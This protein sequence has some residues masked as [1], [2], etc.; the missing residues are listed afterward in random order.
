MH[1]LTSLSFSHPLL[2]PISKLF[3]P[4]GL[5]LLELL[6][7]LFLQCISFSMW[8]VSWLCSMDDEELG[9]DSC[10]PFCWWTLET[11]VCTHS[12]YHHLALSGDLVA[13]FH[14]PQREYTA[15]YWKEQRARWANVKTVCTPVTW[16][17]EKAKETEA[18]LLFSDFKQF[19]VTWW[20]KSVLF[21][22]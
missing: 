15:E 13:T 7:W 17:V 20:Q 21:S 6:C 9:D 16:W 10:M 12:L 1:Q 19:G 5:S 11:R 18:D 2:T 8:A 22:F 4:Y 3:S 14:L